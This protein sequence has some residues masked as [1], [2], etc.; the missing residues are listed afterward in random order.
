MEIRGL[1]APEA[2]LPAA[3]LHASYRTPRGRGCVG[4]PRGRPGGRLSPAKVFPVSAQPASTI[5]RERWHC[6]TPL[7]VSVKARSRAG[8][9]WDFNG[10]L[11]S[12]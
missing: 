2:P 11:K 5:Y 4:G 8:A 9:G 3:R 7:R 1:N 6:F 12:S 10:K